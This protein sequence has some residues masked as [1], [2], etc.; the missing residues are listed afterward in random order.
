MNRTVTRYL[1]RRTLSDQ[2]PLLN[3]P[4]AACRS[5]VVIPCLGEYPGILDTLGDLSNGAASDESLVIVVVNNRVATPASDSSR[6][7]AQDSTQVPA[8]EATND[9]ALNAQ[10]LA[11][12]QDWDQRRL[13]VAWIDASSPGSELPAKQG[14]GL[15]RK[16]GLD[17][18]LQ[19]LAAQ[20]D[21]S[22]PLVCLDG[23]TRVDPD[24]L[25]ALHSFFDAPSRWAGILPYAHPID[26]DAAQQ[27]AILCYEFFLRYHATHLAWAGSP[28]GYHAIGSAMACTAAAYAAISGMNRR[29]AGEDFYFLQQLAKTGSIEVVSGTVVRPSGRPSHRVPFGTGRRVQRF[30]DG[31]NE[32]YQLYHPNSYEIIRQWLQLAGADRDCEMMMQSAADIHPQL[33]TFLLEQKFTDTWNRMRR[34]S[35]PS[36]EARH[37]Q[38]HEWFDG[39][40]TLKLIHHLRDTLWSDAPMFEAIGMLLSRIG[41]E[42][43]VDLTA[44]LSTNLASQQALLQQLREL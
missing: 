5:I 9:I 31:T 42:P 6:D 19:I 16:I 33:A 28:Y 39:F 17:W 32:E 23:D 20:D 21:L 12:L 15:A 38:F 24:Y 27:A 44:P 22:V 25:H 14:V 41:V 29:Q 40:R 2:W 35:S 37:A 36:Q 43:V 13:R 4:S 26:G 34:Q 10:T 8:P 3:A 30:L 18:G 1:E 11:A 7:P